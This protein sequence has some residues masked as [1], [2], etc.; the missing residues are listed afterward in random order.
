MVESLIA[1]MVINRKSKVFVW[2]VESGE[3]HEGGSVR[4]VHCKKQRAVAAALATK[5]VF[6]GGGIHTDECD[7]LE[8]VNGCDYVRVVKFR[9]Q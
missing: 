7:E 5:C 3:K 1:E 8:W 9:V 4:S 6:D 2:V